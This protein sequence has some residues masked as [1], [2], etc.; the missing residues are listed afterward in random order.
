MPEPSP[1]Q[2]EVEIR[3][4]MSDWRSALCAKDLDGM[5][6]H[7]SPDVLFFDV[8]PPYQHKGAAAYRGSWEACF[9]Y[10]PPSIGS[11]M[12]DLNITVNGDMALAHGLHRITDLAT[13]APA[14]CN[15]VRATVVYRRTRGQWQVVHEHVSVPFDPMTSKAAFID[16]P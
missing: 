7:Y 9:P 3:Q 2:D 13:G 12:Q 8:V 1:T 15:W 4:L 5:L 6:R 14:T 10:L 16:H 11:E